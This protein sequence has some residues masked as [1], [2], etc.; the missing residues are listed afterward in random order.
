M[1]SQEPL[2]TLYARPSEL[3]A[4]EQVVRRYISMLEANLPPTGELNCVVARLQSFRR[5][6]QGQLLPEKVR[7]KKK[8][9]RECL[10]PIQASPTELLAFGTAVIGY[11]RLL[12]VGKRPAQPA[13]DILQRVLTFQKRYL[14]AQQA[15]VFP[16]LHD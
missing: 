4:V 10:L 16:H 12:K 8:V 7:T 6:Y 9:V 13:L 11:E 3:Y 1:N 14:D 5:R 15:T 2:I